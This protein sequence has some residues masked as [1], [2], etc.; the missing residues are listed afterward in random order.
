MASLRTAPLAHAPDPLKEF[1]WMED[2]YM[3]DGYSLAA[4]GIL[5]R[6]WYRPRSIWYQQASMQL[7]PQGFVREGL[8]RHMQVW[9]WLEERFNFWAL[10][11]LDF[12]GTPGFEL[13]E[14]G[15]QTWTRMAVF[16]SF[17][18]G[19]RRQ[20]ASSSPT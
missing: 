7:R 9:N 16:G 11:S 19:P 1:P 12:E 8:E 18:L 5:L 2:V 6:V 20:T 13:N 17:R 10:P 15:P 3:W 4:P 14:S